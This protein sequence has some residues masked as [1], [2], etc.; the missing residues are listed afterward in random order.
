LMSSHLDFWRPSKRQ[1]ETL[2]DCV[3]ALLDTARTAA[4]LGVD[5]TMFVAWT[6]RLASAAAEEERLLA[7]FLARP[8]GVAHEL[9][10]ISALGG[11]LP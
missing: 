5:E 11:R 3:A 8:R 2:A 9:A 1:L 10:E 4:L 7:A 6:K